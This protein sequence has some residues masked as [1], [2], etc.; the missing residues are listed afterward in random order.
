MFTVPTL[1]KRISRASKSL[2]TFLD[3]NIF[4]S[5]ALHSN[6]FDWFKF[7][8]SASSSVVFNAIY[9]FYVCFVNFYINITSPRF[10][11]LDLKIYFSAPSKKKKKLHGLFLSAPILNIVLRISYRHLIVTFEI[12]QTKLNVL[13][14]C[15]K[16]I[17]SY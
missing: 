2:G 11:I 16:I 10:F 15:K 5:F 1:E 12:Q 3:Y 14:F 7:N 6:V 13:H 9:F 4:F 8:F 17:G